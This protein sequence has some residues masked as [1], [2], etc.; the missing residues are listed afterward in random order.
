MASP[1]VEKAGGLAVMENRAAVRT[2]DEARRSGG[3]YHLYATRTAVIRRADELAEVAARGTGA[4][5]LLDGDSDA[6]GRARSATE[7]PLDPRL[8]AST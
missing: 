7:R 4:P 5:V 2:E 1:P 8:E 3:A 6:H